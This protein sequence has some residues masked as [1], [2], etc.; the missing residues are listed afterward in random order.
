MNNLPTCRAGRLKSIWRRLV[1]IAMNNKFWR[2][3]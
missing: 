2:M 3:G 1:R